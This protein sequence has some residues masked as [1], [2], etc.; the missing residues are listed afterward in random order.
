MSRLL[1][2][3]NTKQ[4]KYYWAEGI[5]TVAWYYPGQ[6]RPDGVLSPVS[7]HLPFNK[8]AVRAAYGLRK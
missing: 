1:I 6:R 4:T 3:I 7:V 5:A 2:V 8:I